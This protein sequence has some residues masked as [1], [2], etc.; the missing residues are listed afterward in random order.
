MR[1]ST[2]FVPLRMLLALSAMALA[3]VLGSTPSNAQQ[4]AALAAT[5]ASKT[6]IDPIVTGVKLTAEQL[7][8]WKVRQAKFQACGLCG[9]GQPFPGDAG[10]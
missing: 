7:A 10:E 1:Q 8:R 2:S 4:L 3:L 5:S 6:G 9:E